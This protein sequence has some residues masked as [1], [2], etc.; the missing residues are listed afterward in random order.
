MEQ[1]QGYLESV[2]SLEELV[3]VTSLNINEVKT[4]DTT[5]GRCY[6]F[7]NSIPATLG[8]DI[9]IWI[10]RNV[11][12]QVSLSFDNKCRLLVRFCEGNQMKYKFKS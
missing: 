7:C 10:C 12:L 1:F 6:T 5:H 2:F 3:N 9:Y 11:S 8:E 4:L